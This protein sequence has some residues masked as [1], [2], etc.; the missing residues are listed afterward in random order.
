MIAVDW[1]STSLRAYRLDGS[2]A[3]LA[4]RRAEIGALSCHGRFAET[5]AHHIHDW[6][7]RSIMMCGMVG[8]RGGWHE[9]PYVPCPAGVHEI[10]ASV[11]AVQAGTAEPDERF[12]AGR[13]VR[14]VP[15]MIDRNNSVPDVMRGEETQIVGLL[16]TLDAG[17]QT[18]CLPGTHSKWVCVRDREIISIHTAMTGE[19][20]ALFRTHSVLA[21]LMSADDQPLDRA[22]F[23]AGLQ[24]SA[25]PGGLLHHLFGVRTAGLLGK[26]STTQSPS[27][28]SG[29]LIGHEIRAQNPRPARV[30]LVGNDRLLT[31]YAHALGEF[32]IEACRHSEELAA[33]GLY[34]L[35]RLTA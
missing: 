11:V 15:G 3:V 9:V 12:L 10:A 2:G 28:L 26:L 33:L 8:G 18:L 22:A 31:V 34:R 5:L 17:I 1:G 14:I 4:Q 20:Y 23:G 25:E 19:A 27:Y 32:G 13:D 35:S 29:L 30:H 24:R 6:D 7:D 16:D 21:K